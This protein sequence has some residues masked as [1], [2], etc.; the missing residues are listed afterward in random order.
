MKQTIRWIA[1]AMLVAHG[2]FAADEIQ[3]QLKMSAIK[4]SIVEQVQPDARSADWN[5]SGIY[6]ATIALTTNPVALS[7]GAIVNPGF[8]FFQNTGTNYTL[9]LVF[10]GGTNTPAMQLKAGEYSMLRL[11]TNCIVSNMRA[12]AS[13]DATNTATT[14]LYY[15]LLED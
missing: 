1:A 6:A 2:A 11:A 10:D 14:G 12:W 13:R 9:C 15:K 3:M 5:G 4:G 7:Q 8:G